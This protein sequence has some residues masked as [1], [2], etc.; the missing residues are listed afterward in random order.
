MLEDASS[1]DVGAD[2]PPPKCVV[3]GKAADMN[4]VGWARAKLQVCSS[5]LCTLG[6]A[7]DAGAFAV[8]VGCGERYHV[9]ALPPPGDARA[10]SAG[11]GIIKDPVIHDYA[12]PDLVRIP[13]TANAIA[14]TAGVQSV[15]VAPDLTLIADPGDIG[16][17]GAAYLAGVLVPQAKWP[18]FEIAGRT[19]LAMWALGPWA[20]TTK[21][22][23]TIG[24]L[25]KNG[26]GLTA[27]DRVGVYAVSQTT[28]DL[29][30]P[31]DATTD[32]AAK[33]VTGGT[34]DRVTW[35]V[36]AR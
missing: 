16:F 14:L 36:I 32:G 17:A 30:T 10:A 29:S 21:K 19:I 9:L 22:G 1:L 28:A 34:I 11:I 31:V 18:S 35:I 25:V 8:T 20:A 5:L 27:G 33:L 26:F 13:E 12:L 15:A 23:K 6:D 2:E 7:D 3:S 4:D 24:V